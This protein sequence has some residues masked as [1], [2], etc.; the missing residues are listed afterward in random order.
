MIH[1]YQEDYFRKV[2]TLIS[3]QHNHLVISLIVNLPEKQFIFYIGNCSIISKFILDLSTKCERFKIEEKCA[4][5][6]LIVMALVNIARVSLSKTMVSI[7]NVRLL[8]LKHR[9]LPSLRLMMQRMSQHPWLNMMKHKKFQLQTLSQVVMK[10]IIS[11]PLRFLGRK[12][13]SMIIKVGRMM[14]WKVMN[15]LCMLL[16]GLLGVLFLRRIVQKRLRR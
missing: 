15:N 3:T 13:L 2:Y 14:S 5:V 11:L 7:L 12:P 8:F 16:I 6:E 1:D 4:R 10:I 9:Q